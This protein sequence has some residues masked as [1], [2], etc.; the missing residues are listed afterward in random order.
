MSE[1]TAIPYQTLINLYGTVNWA[2]RM[3][4]DMRLGSAF[5]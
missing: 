2:S 1:E 5:I 3:T 4:W